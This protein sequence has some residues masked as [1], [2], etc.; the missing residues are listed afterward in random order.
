MPGMDR[1]SVEAAVPY[2]WEAAPGKPISDVNNISTEPELRAPLP[3]PPGSRGVRKPL[4]YAEPSTFAGFEPEPRDVAKSSVPHFAEKLFKKLQT[5]LR[6]KSKL[7]A[8]SFSAE[9]LRAL[10]EHKKRTVS[11]EDSVQSRSYCSDES[12]GG[13]WSSSSTVEQ[14]DTPCSTDSVSMGSMSSMSSLSNAS[15]SW[16]SFGN[17]SALHQDGS[18][19]NI[20][21]L[22][23]LS[24][25]CDDDFQDDGVAECLSGPRESAWHEEAEDEELTEQEWQIVRYASLNGDNSSLISTLVRQSSLTPLSDHSYRFSPIKGR[26]SE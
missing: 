24:A 1:G 16:E 23:A 15:T 7:L 22:L 13:S 18:Q 3:P 2:S 17:H 9:N 21:L 26:K 14:P 11:I 20:D 25:S 12:V 4:T 10:S 8:A 5:K 19:R 6:K